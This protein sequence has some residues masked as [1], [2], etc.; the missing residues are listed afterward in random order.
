MCLMIGNNKIEDG[1]K[2]ATS[3]TQRAFII[4]TDAAIEAPTIAQIT[5]YIE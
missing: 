4:R 1:V 2:G 3:T 5:G